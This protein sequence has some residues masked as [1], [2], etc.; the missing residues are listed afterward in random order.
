MF[1]N[2]SSWCAWVV[3]VSL[4]VV[5]PSLRAQTATTGGLTGTVTDSTGAVIANAAVTVSSTGT[6]Q[7]RTA[8]TGSDGSY[9]VGLLPPGTYRVKFE[10]SGF[11]SAEVPSVTVNVTETALLNQTLTVGSQSQAVEVQAEAETVQTT[12]ATV[13]TVMPGQTIADLPLTSRN[14]T[15]LLGLTAGSNVSVF[16]AA[17]VGKGTQDIAVNGGATTDNNF[18]QDGA[19]IE[20]SSGSGSAGVLLALKAKCGKHRRERRVSSCMT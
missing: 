7:T 3:F 12:D 2:K 20:L 1:K 15:N 8:M 13:G 6:S 17:N 4:V 14:Y 11:N 9:K 19:P 18:L 10:V 5:A 16:N